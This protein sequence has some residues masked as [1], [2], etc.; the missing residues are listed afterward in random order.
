MTS[1]LSCLIPSTVHL[2]EIIFTEDGK[3]LALHSSLKM[4]SSKLGSLVEFDGCKE[5]PC[6]PP[7]KNFSPFLF[8]R[9]TDLPEWSGLLSGARALHSQELYIEQMSE[10]LLLK[11]INDLEENIYILNAILREIPMWFYFIWKCK[12]MQLVRKCFIFSKKLC[13]SLLNNEVTCIAV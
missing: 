2:W 8:M 5:N 13:L 4:E 7:C 11:Y 9:R 3:N 10:C 1:M 12:S 6:P